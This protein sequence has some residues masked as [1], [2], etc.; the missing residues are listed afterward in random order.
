METISD[1]KKPIVKITKSMKR[2]IILMLTALAV[3]LT[4][5]LCA[6]EREKGVRF[7]G[8]ADFVSGY[9]WRGVW[10]AGPSIQPTLTMT[11][12][13][14]SVT[15]WGSVDFSATDYKEMD[16]TLA[17]TLGP[18]A[19]SLADL[20]W[21]G[22]NSDR[23]G[24]ISRN[25][26]HFGADSPHRVEAGIAWCISQRVP[27]TLSWNTVLFGA[28]DRNSKGERAY[29]TYIEASYPFTVKGIDMK[30][31]VGVV[32][33]NAYV[34]YGADRDFYV[35]NVFLNAGKS[36]TVAKSLQL[37]IFTNLGW[38]PALEDVNFV[39]GISLRM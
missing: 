9:I 36:W 17:Y 5:D 22:G 8:G 19:F 27:V 10:E 1:M 26:F 11:A 24:S 4:T 38:N 31:G 29:A 18:V 33:W 21:E 2:L 7:S 28:V 3:M 15:A 25:Y 20:Y 13:N 16:L 35:Q 30:A 12:G 23:S 34:T 32:P 6:Q 37:G 39:G 14:F